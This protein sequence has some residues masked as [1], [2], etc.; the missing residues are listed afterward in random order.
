MADQTEGFN[1]PVHLDFDQID[2]V[3]E[4]AFGRAP[5][6]LV[7]EAEKAGAKRKRVVTGQGGFFLQYSEM[8]PGYRVPPHA[9]GHDEMIVVLEG[10]AEVDG[11]I[12]LDENDTIV[13]E[14]NFE[15]GFT[16]GDRGMRFMTIRAADSTTTVVPDGEETAA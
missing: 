13:L 10:G 11:G 9:H 6:A 8:P 12:V 3:D 2:W 15:Y 16:C 5:A 1:G 4:R 7:E 14:A